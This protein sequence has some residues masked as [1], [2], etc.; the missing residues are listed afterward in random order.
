MTVRANVAIAN[1]YAEKTGFAIQCRSGIRVQGTDATVIGNRGYDNVA[2]G[3]HVEAKDIKAQFANRAARN[4][5]AA[6]CLGVVCQ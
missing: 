4:G 3:L 5:E 1:G 6:G 2:Y